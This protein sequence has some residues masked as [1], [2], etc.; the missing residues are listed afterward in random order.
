MLILFIPSFSF[1]Q[2]FRFGFSGSILSDK[3]TGIDNDTGEEGKLVSNTNFHYGIHFAYLMGSGFQILLDY[4]NKSYDFDNTQEIITGEESFSLTKTSIG[5][6]WIA[7]P[8]I[9]LRLHLN[10]DEDIVF[11]VDENN[12][13][14]IEPEK[15]I[16]PS[17]F[18]DQILFLGGSMYSG[19]KVGYEL[20]GT[21]E[22]I[23]NR[24]ALQYGLFAVLNAFEINYMIKNITKE[25][26]TL[27]FTETESALNFIYLFRF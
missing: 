26:D 18:Y 17:I 6:R 12:Q 3:I 1:A 20:G 11:T 25:N 16:Y 10:F 13:A 8:R 14:L 9:A 5:M 15:I 21:G 23:K 27:E 2:Q 7:H 19:F 22:T 24:T 4:Q